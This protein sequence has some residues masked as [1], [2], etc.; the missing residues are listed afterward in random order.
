LLAIY[1]GVILSF[2]G[3]MIWGWPNEFLNKKVLF[4]GVLFS[5]VGFVIIFLVQRHLL[6]TLILNFIFFPL[7]Y[8]FEKNNSDM[9]LDLDY[10]K[11]RLSLTTA[12]SGCYL[13]SFL[14][15]L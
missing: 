3:G 10:Q 7:F 9:F 14:N 5:L 13:L 12:V 8:L 1:G 11:L 2:L 4:L 6:L 15:F